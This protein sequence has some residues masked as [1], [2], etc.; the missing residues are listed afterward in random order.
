MILFIYL[1]SWQSFKGTT[2]NL[3]VRAETGNNNKKQNKQKP[4]SIV[5]QL[6]DAAATY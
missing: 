1:H 4:L 2:T 5:C 6:K 3:S